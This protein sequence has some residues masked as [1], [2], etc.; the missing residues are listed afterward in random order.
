MIV[1]VVLDANTAYPG[2]VALIP[3][4]AA[5]V[6]I[7][8]GGLRF[9]PGLLLRL[10]PIRFLGRIS[11]SLYLWHW[12][13]LVLG[14][15]AIGAELNL[16]QTIGLVG[17]AVALAVLTW[18]FVEEP[19]RRGRIPALTMPRVTVAAGV[20]TMLVVAL[21]ANGLA[22]ADQSTLA[23]L[24]SPAQAV[25]AGA[26]PPAGPGS[27][28]GS[29]SGSAAPGNSGASAGSTPRASTQPGTA[30]P[31]PKAPAPGQ[32]TATPGPPTAFQLTSAVRPSLVDAR[33]DYERTWTDGCLG[34]LTTTVPK[35]CRYANKSGSFTV[36]LVGDS[37]ASALFP[38]VAAV[39]SAHGWQLLTFVK[40]SC[41]F[42]DMPIYSTMLKRE[43]TECATWNQNVVARLDA[44]KP[45]LVLVSDSRWVFPLNSADKS[46][47]KEGAALARMIDQLQS[48]VVIINDVP[49]PY[50]DVP[51]CLAAHAND[52]RQ[53]A[54]PRSQDLGDGMG[55]IEKA[56][57]AA[58]GA[59]FVD[60]TAGI[61]PGNGPCPVVLNNMILYRDGHHLTATFSKTLAPLL[62]RRLRALGIT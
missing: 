30:G 26:S 50:I 4:T 62:D 27:Q 40:V 24:T 14:G 61:C 36:A 7:A 8:G 31:T 58:T 57:A 20:A 60:L 59:G 44:V 19:F 21:L 35:D 17:I 9:G 51:A 56:A 6:L 48:R 39:A 3:T 15:L 46:R 29:A 16:G 5:V 49:L 54:I 28:S 38:A 12:P 25:S 41:P 45:D 32:P 55:L 47:A 23:S 22:A 33:T 18:A 37:H 42:F 53:C 11:Y 2:L 43:Y 10:L 52:V 1:A 13:V 34:S